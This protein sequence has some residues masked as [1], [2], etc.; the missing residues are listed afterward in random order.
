MFVLSR[1]DGNNVTTTYT[2]N[3]P[4]SLLTDVTYPSGTI[5]SVHYAYDSYGRRQSMTD[6]TGGQTYAYDDDNTLTTKNVTWTG[7]SAK[8][9]SYGF[10]PDGSRKTMTA[11]GGAFTYS[12]DGDGRRQ[13][14][15]NPFNQQSAWGYQDNGWLQNKTLA[16]GITTTYTHDP[17]GRLT[18][19]LNSQNG[20]TLSDFRVPATGGYDGVGNRLSVTAN[21]PGTQHTVASA[22]QYDYGQTQN[23]Q[24]SRSQ[25]TQETTT[26]LGGDYGS[27]NYAYDGGTSTGAGNPTTFG[28][29]TNTFNADNQITGS[30]YGY[31]GNGNATTYTQP[32]NQLS[33]QQSHPLTFDPENRLTAYDSA[34]TN[35]YDGDGLRTWEQ[36]SGGSHYYYL[37]DGSQ[38]VGE[39]GSSGVL[40]A[41]NTFGADGP[42]FTICH[43]QVHHVYV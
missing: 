17:Q 1:T 34:Q 7:L 13:V 31:D 20:T 10:Y 33:T 27:V 11:D 8:T 23:P 37:Y 28:D 29:F 35:G 32:S 3:D 42:G 14:W 6:G 19:L 16:N 30:G 5:G 21:V 15:V 2:Y 26:L 39:Y 9:L 12:Y 4:E 36:Y 25:L 40:A 18:E 22:Y 43:R 24:A 38:P 41:T